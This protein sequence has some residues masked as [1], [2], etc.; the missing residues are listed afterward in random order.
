MT[1]EL[2]SRL[3]Q[4]LML[5]NNMAPKALAKAAGVD[6]SAVH[7]LL[8]ARLPTDGT[9]GIH[10]NTLW[11]ICR[12]LG[13]QPGELL[14]LE[15]PQ[16]AGFVREVGGPC[17]L[18]TGSNLYLALD[19]GT[20]VDA[21]VRVTA[22]RR[23]R[24][25]EYWDASARA[26]ILRHVSW[27]VPTEQE[28]PCTLTQATPQLPHAVQDVLLRQPGLLI[29][30]GSELVSGLSD[31]MLLKMHQG[32]KAPD[33]PPFYVV[34]GHQGPDQRPYHR[35]DAR[36]GARQGIAQ[37][38]PGQFLVTVPSWP[39]IA[40][41][42]EGYTY[43]DACLL[44]VCPLNRQNGTY[45]TY[46]V[47]VLGFMGP[48]TLAGASFLFSPNFGHLL[49]AYREQVLNHPAADPQ[50]PVPPLGVVLCVPCQKRGGPGTHDVEV[51][52]AS[53]TVVA[54]HP[55][56]LGSGATA[57]APGPVPLSRRRRRRAGG[58][59]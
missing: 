59:S 31:V 13:C 56:W 33:R 24:A 51:N 41:E 30:V 9:S 10:W 14:V 4:L 11:R 34:W 7:A 20:A 22:E 47:L 35:Y 23:H 45:R 43:T 36:P 19:P 28:T 49:T 50:A 46:V 6:I 2:V 53:V 39:T 29:S 48:G 26:T 5:R 40:A 3:P 32:L 44:L 52:E 17:T 42:S 38:A 15:E 1:G 54:T 37:G 58:G 57:Q 18:V 8:V 27:P 12:A 16:F 55:G 21:K 25:V